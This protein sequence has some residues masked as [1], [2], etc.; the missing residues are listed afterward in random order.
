MVRHEQMRQNK[1]G[2]SVDAGK[3]L[4]VS[5]LLTLNTFHSKR[6]FCCCYQHGQTRG[7]RRNEIS[8]KNSLPTQLNARRKEKN[9]LEAAVVGLLP[10]KVT[11][12]YT[13]EV[14]ECFPHNSM[15]TLGTTGSTRLQHTATVLSSKCTQCR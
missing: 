5:R 11:T 1:H 15:D 2:S 9:S 3:G 12:V 13:A 10:P 4:A 14:R 6:A 7:V 8:S